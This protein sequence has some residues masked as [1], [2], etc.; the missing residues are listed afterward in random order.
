VEQALID[1][2]QAYLDSRAAKDATV[3]LR[4]SFTRVPIT[5]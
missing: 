4:D 3:T 2:I 5:R 1:V